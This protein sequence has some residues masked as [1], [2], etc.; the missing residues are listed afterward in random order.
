MAVCVRIFN[1]KARRC[2][3]K[4]G[5]A[6]HCA[7]NR[8]GQ[9]TARPTG[10]RVLT[11]R[12]H[13]TR[14]FHAFYVAQTSKFMACLPT[15]LRLITMQVLGLAQAGIV[16]HLSLQ[17]FNALRI[18]ARAQP[19][20]ARPQSRFIP[21]RAPRHNGLAPPALQVREIS[22]LRWEAS[23]KGLQM[24]EVSSTVAFAGFET[25]QP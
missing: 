22:G 1:A 7:L 25:H 3:V 18:P 8:G 15:C 2:G 24:C 16:S 20:A 23:M 5:Q 21:Q 17:H 9:Q 6:V 12:N 13:L 10:D 4:V 11:K 19:S 14:M